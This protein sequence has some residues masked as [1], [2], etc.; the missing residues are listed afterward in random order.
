MFNAILQKIAALPT[1]KPTE[2]TR[3]LDLKIHLRPS[4]AMTEMSPILTPFRG[5]LGHF[6]A[7]SLGIGRAK[8]F[9]ILVDLGEGV[10]GGSRYLNELVIC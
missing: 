10:G 7:C 5:V 4:L 9:R 6:L 2:T 8:S 3:D 1:R